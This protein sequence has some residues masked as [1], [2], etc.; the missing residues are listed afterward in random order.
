MSDAADAARKEVA[1]A[2]DDESRKAVIEKCTSDEAFDEWY[3]GFSSALQDAVG[4]Q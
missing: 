3:D 4:E 2:S 1:A